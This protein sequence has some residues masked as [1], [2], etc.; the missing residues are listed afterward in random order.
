[1]YVMQIHSRM[2]EQ[3]MEQKESV[4]ENEISSDTENHLAKTKMWKERESGVEWHQNE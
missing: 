2:A 3:S 1:M 4:R